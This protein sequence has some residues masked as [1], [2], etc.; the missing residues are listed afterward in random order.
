MQDCNR[1]VIDQ[2]QPVPCPAAR[3]IGTDTTTIAPLSRLYTTA[4][5]PCGRFG[6]AL[7][8]HTPQQRLD[9]RRQLHQR[10]GLDQIVVATGLEP[11]HP[12]V[13]L[14]ERREDDHR[15]L[16]LRGAQRRDDSQ[17]IH[18]RQHAVDDAPVIGLGQRQ[19]QT[20]ATVRRRVDG[21]AG[22]AQRLERKTRLFDAVWARAVRQMN[23][24]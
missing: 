5:P 10:I 17:A 6:A 13:D 23:V 8:A 15:G 20:V 21:M 22:F 24:L 4:S 16:L 12:V 9:A 2:N 19:E 18:P 1:P 3:W 7:V 14:A 11:A